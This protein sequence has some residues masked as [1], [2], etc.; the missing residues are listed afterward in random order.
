MVGLPCRPAGGRGYR[1]R[2]CLHPA[3]P[4]RWPERGGGSARHARYQLAAWFPAA[5][6]TNRMSIRCQSGDDVDLDL[7][8]RHGQCAD[9][10]EGARRASLAEDLLAHRVDQRRVANVGQVGSDFEDIAER[11]PCRGED[12]LQVAKDLPRLLNYVAGDKLAVGCNARATG[13]EQQI[14]EP[15]RLRIMAERWP[16]ARGGDFLTSGYAHGSTL[17]AGSERW[18]IV[19]P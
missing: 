4:G 1:R 16:Q 19:A 2:L 5:A 17:G 8:A 6:L 15:H 13:Y 18:R 11:R 14:P 9:L 7:G 10:D 3:G 12:R